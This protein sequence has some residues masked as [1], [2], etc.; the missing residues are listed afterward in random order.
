MEYEFTVEEIKDR[1]IRLNKECHSD[2]DK[3][4]LHKLID[5]LFDRLKFGEFL[6]FMKSL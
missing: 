3:K 5:E 4:I 6:D 2:I 1:V